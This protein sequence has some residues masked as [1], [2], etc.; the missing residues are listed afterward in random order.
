LSSNCWRNGAA[1]YAYW[2]ELPDCWPGGAR[3]AL[4]FIRINIHIVIPPFIQATFSFIQRY[5]W[6]W[7]ERLENNYLE[8][9]SMK[10]GPHIRASRCWCLNDYIK[11][12]LRSRYSSALCISRYPNS[13]T[14]SVWKNMFPS[15]SLLS[16]YSQCFST[17]IYKGL[18]RY[19]NPRSGAIWDLW[20]FAPLS[21]F[22]LIP[23]Y[24]FYLVTFPEG[25]RRCQWVGL[26]IDSYPL[27]SGGDTTDQ[28]NS[29]RHDSFP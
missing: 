9:H 23:T 6:W 17:T 7:R 2:M 13:Q 29:S 18:C 10:N 8:D 3:Y 4:N 21:H 5:R 11:I 26:S 15:F 14:A 24:C 20:N 12:D 25:M 22:K 27:Y 28:F 1:V 16:V 19:W